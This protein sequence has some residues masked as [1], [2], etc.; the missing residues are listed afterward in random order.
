MPPALHFSLKR[1]EDLKIVHWHAR[2]PRN[3]CTSEQLWI[4]GPGLWTQRDATAGAQTAAECQVGTNTHTHT[5]TLCRHGWPIGVRD[6]NHAATHAICPQT[7]LPDLFMGGHVS[8]R[9]AGDARRTRCSSIETNIQHQTLTCLCDLLYN[10]TIHFKKCIVVRLLMLLFKA[11]SFSL[12]DR[13]VVQTA[14]DS[15]LNSLVV[16]YFIFEFYWLIL[17]DLTSSPI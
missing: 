7:G 6:D 10:S 11:F 12:L 13:F 16:K 1:S 8:L 4:L 3:L 17:L 14:V 15:W 2:S 9:S 5:H